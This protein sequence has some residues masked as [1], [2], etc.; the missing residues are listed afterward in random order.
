[1]PLRYASNLGW[2]AMGIAATS[3]LAWI[4]WQAVDGQLPTKVQLQYA[5]V[6]PLLIVVSIAGG[7]LAVFSFAVAHTQQSIV[8]IGANRIVKDM[9]ALHPPKTPDELPKL[10]WH[11]RAWVTIKATLVA[12]GASAKRMAQLKAGRRW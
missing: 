6:S 5:W 10:A 9:D 3:I 7:V 11:S 4:P 2:T 1:M 12:D 8:C